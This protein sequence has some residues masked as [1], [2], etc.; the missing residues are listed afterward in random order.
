MKPACISDNGSAKETENAGHFRLLEHPFT[1][2]SKMPKGS[3]GTEVLQSDRLS[4]AETEE[5]PANL[6][7]SVGSKILSICK[8]DRASTNTVFRI[9]GLNLS[10]TDIHFSRIEQESVLPKGNAT[11]N[12]K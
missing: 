2:P 3:L 6:S 10:H 7:R 11:L 8:G 4:H 5:M 12:I 9:S 1:S